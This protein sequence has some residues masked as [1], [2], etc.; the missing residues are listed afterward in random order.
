M[1]TFFFD[2]FT[3]MEQDSKKKFSLSDIKNKHKRLE[4]YHKLK[5][6][7]A[8]THKAARA[9]KKDSKAPK[10]VPKTLDS[11][12]E[13]EMTMTGEDVEELDEFSRDAFSKFYETEENGCGI[14]VSEN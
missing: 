14:E 3:K 6:L 10:E 2:S 12:R 13:A 4:V 9:A 1:D 7:K 5:A 11:M 8:K